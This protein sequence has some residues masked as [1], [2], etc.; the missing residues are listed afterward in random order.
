MMGPA[1]GDEAEGSVPDRLLSLCAKAGY[2]VVYPE[3]VSAL[4]CGM[5]FN[6]RGFASTAA[7]KSD[8]LEAALLRASQNGK[9]PIVVDTSPCLKQMKESF[10]S[11][12]LKVL[13]P[14]APP[15]L[16]SKPRL[17]VLAK[18]GGGGMVHGVNAYA[19]DC[20]RANGEIA[21]IVSLFSAPKM[22]ALYEPVA[23]IDKFLADRLEFSRVKDSVA[24]HVPCSSKKLGLEPAFAR[25]AAKCADKVHASGVPCCGMAGDRGMRYPELTG[26]ALQHLALPAGCTDGYSTSRTCEMSLSNHSG[27]HFRGLVHLVDQATKPKAAVAAAGKP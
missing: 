23:F 6:S 14:A 22:G 26:G 27:V 3:G 2:Q 4:C 19:K 12:L 21:P 18:G 1:R 5:M 15:A 11:P 7:G 16:L 17:H 8:E 10:S 24:I 13:C 9:Y 20:S 25:L